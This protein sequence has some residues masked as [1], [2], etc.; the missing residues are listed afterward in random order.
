MR[1]RKCTGTIHTGVLKNT[2]VSK[3]ALNLKNNYTQTGLKTDI[4]DYT[5]SIIYIPILSK[6]FYSYFW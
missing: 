2:N 6:D 3:E 4:G 5:N 1:R